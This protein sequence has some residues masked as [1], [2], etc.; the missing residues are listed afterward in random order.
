LD[1]GF[2]QE[3]EMLR[4]S[5]RAMLER[6][7]TS[8]H[9]R[10]MME[11]DRGYSPELWRRMAELGW[12]GLVLPDVYGGAGLD[13]IDMVVVAE[14]MG[15]VL[16]PSPF[17]WTLIFAE[18]IRQAGSDEQRRRFLPE[19]ARGELVA[20]PAYL[21]AG[22]SCEESA[23]TLG[24]RKNGASFTLEGEKMF[25]N[26]AHVADFFL[27]A[28]RTGG[29]RGAGVTLFAIDAARQG[30]AV[31]ALKAMDQTRKLGMVTFD[32]VRAGA[33]D[34]VGV[35]NGGRPVLESAIDRAKVAL[36]AEMLGGAQKVMETAVAYSKVRE[37][38]GRAIGS[39]QAVQ[40]K[41]A[42]MMVDIEGAK[43]AVYYAAWAVSNGAP[44][45]RT[46][47]AV[48]KAAASDA[49]RRVA[50]DGI[51]VHGGIGFT[52][53]HD[54]HLYF[55]RAKSSEFTFG[56]ANFNRELVAQLIGL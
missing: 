6:E 35:V 23:L 19:I 14:E 16:L 22:G 41:C 3:Q 50:A 43:S 20:T 55:K 30:V 10:R 13:Y 27:V 51:Q 24:A 17:I 25:V 37:Q 29:K 18:A 1:F 15:R 46:A 4:Q 12:L 32:G 34:V 33:A 38:F 8:A 48:A 21:E 44:D 39:F 53:E 40:H 9:V 11:D 5:A 56:D 52:W 45:A 42:N 26:D 7:C 28:A 54:M 2:S 36:A 31:T 49:Y 47:A